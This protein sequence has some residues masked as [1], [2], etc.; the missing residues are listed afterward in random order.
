MVRLVLSLNA[1]RVPFSSWSPSYEGI[2]Y[3]DAVNHPRISA[4]KFGRAAILMLGVFP[5]ES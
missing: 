5:R 2:F 4:Y 3:G 1:K